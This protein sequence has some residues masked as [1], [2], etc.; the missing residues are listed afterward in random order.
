MIPADFADDLEEA[1]SDNSFV[2]ITK[3]DGRVFTGA[4]HR[5]PTDPELFTVRTGGRGRPAVI[6][7]ADVEDLVH[8]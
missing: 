8:E 1:A 2:T 6:H 5:H 3:T 4:V 7:P